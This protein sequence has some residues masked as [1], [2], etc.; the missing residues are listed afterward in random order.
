MR[1]KEFLQEIDKAEKQLIMIAAH[2]QHLMDLATSIG[3]KLTGM[4]GNK[5]PSSRVETGA[6]GLVDLIVDLT[7]KERE[8]TQLVVKAKELISKVP[9]EK[10]QEILTLKYLCHWSWKSIRD[11]MGYK[12]EKSVYRC[13]GYAL[14]ELQK[15]M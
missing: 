3:V 5:A 14:R 10:F 7:D 12:D 11:E 2:K 8:Y 1:A 15:V 13:H 6:V 4:P 9:Q